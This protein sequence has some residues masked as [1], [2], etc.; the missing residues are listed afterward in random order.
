MPI[1]PDAVGATSGPVEQSWTST[2]ALLYAVGVGAGWP[3]PLEELAFTTENTDDEPQRILP[4]YGVLITQ[5]ARLRPDIG[6]FDPARVV[7]VVQPV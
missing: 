6:D 4:S 1:N 7:H 5:R 2:D 3:D